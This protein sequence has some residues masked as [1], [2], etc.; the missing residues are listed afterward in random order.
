M[1]TKRKS[2]RSSKRSPKH[3]KVGREIIQGMKEAVAY[4]RGDMELRK[5]S[6]LVPEDVD[7]RAIRE[8]TGLSQFKFAEAFGF[9]PRTLQDWEQGRARPDSAVR[10]YLKVISRDPVTVQQTLLAE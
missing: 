7:V 9:N 4:M 2:V 6:Y 1:T 3:S 8:L 5:T 10:A